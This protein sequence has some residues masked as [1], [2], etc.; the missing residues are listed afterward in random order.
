MDQRN[1]KVGAMFCR[2]SRCR[3]RSRNFLIGSEGREVEVKES[4]GIGQASCPGNHHADVG[5]AAAEDRWQR[6]P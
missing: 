5:V 4:R 6:L 3:L 1:E 2:H